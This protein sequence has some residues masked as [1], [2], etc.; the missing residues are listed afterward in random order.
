[1][2]LLTLPNFITMIGDRAQEMSLATRTTAELV[3]YMNLATQDIRG[4]HDWPEVIGSATVAFTSHATLPYNTI[5]LSS[6]SSSIADIW[7]PIDFNNATNDYKFWWMEPKALRDLS[8][9]DFDTYEDIDHAIAIEGS[10]MLIYHN[11]A[12]T[13]TIRYYSKYLVDTATSGV[14][15]ETWESTGA[16]ADTFRLNNDD[17]LLTRTLMYLAQKETGQDSQYMLLKQEFD[18]YL[19]DERLL[20]PSQRMERVEPII[21]IG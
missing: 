7:A 1:M 11:K 2:S 9:G 18:Q 13:M 15:K 8:R 19:E 20:N 3:R 21:T 14:D 16:N 17:M 10:N 4:K 12:E 5:A 6:F